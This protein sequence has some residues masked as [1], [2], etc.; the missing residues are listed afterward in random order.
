[1]MKT[2]DNQYEAIESL[3]IG[4]MGEVFKVVD[5]NDNSIKALKI[6]K[7]DLI[8]EL[9]WFKEEF[10]IL[11]Q[12]R[13]PY[14]VRVYNF[15][16]ENDNNPYYTMDLMPGGDIKIKAENCPLDE[17]YK[18]ALMSLSALDYI[19][20]RNII[21]GDL[22]PSNILF[23]E[24]GNLRLVD[25]GL[26]VHLKSDRS[27]SSGTLE[28]ASP[29]IIKHGKLSS[30]SDLYSLG[31]VLYELLFDKP[32]LKGTTSQI[33]A[34]K[35][36]KPVELPEF[37][38]D[39]GG[40]NL[41]QVI[42]RLLENDPEKR[43]QVA[44]E[45]SAIIENLYHASAPEGKLANDRLP[46]SVMSDTSRDYFERASFCGRNEEFKALKKA[47]S[48][49]SEGENSIYYL[50]GESGVGKSRLAEQ[51]KYDIQME[52][53]YFVQSVC[54]PGDDQP[55]APIRK[56][57]EQLFILFDPDYSIFK[58]L[59]D[60]VKRL[61]PEIFQDI[62]GEQDVNRGKQRLFYN[63]QKYIEQICSDNSLVLLVEDL[64]YADSVTI[65]FINLISQSS[66]SSYRPA[67][68]GFLLILTSQI[69]PD[70]SHWDFTK[71]AR[72]IILKPADSEL[73]DE[74]L[75]NLFG[76]FKPPADFS[77]KLYHETGG[78][79]FFAEELLKSLADG[80]ALIRSEGFWKLETEKLTDFPLPGSVKEAISH[81][82]SYLGLNYRAI[83]EQAT[84]MDTLFKPADLLELSGFSDKDNEL[85]DELIL[86]RVFRRQNGSLQ[87]LHN[88]VK[89]VAYNSL[90]SD[91]K[92]KLHYQAAIYFEKRKANPE[93]LAA[94]FLA[95]GE[96]GK[97]YKYLCQSA[98]NAVGIFGWSQAANYYKQIIELIADWPEAPKSARFDALSGQARAL[99]FID[100]KAAE[101]LFEDIQLE[102]VKTDFSSKNSASALVLQAENYQ[103]LGENEQALKLY[104]KAINFSS[105][106]EDAPDWSNILGEAYMGFGW[107]K[108]KLG[109]LD[110]AVKSYFKALDY[111]I[112][113]PERMCRV[114][115]YI[116]IGYARKG[117]FDGALDYYNRSLTVCRENNYKWPAM[118]LYGNIGNVY[119]AKGE[120]DEALEHYKKSLAIALEIS[121]K[122]I[123]G[124]N[125][126]N[127]GHIYNHLDQR[128]KAL[129]YFQKALQIQK[130]IG[131]RGSEAINYN[132]L[133]ET[134]FNLGQLKRAFDYSI[135][136]IELAK[137]IKEPR[138]ELANLKGL[139]DVYLSI[140][141][142][143][144]AYEN[145][146]TALTLAEKLNDDQQK[147]WVLAIKAE[148]QFER[149]DIDDSQK[150]LSDALAAK[151]EH[152]GL[153]ARL[154]MA[155]ALV[156]LKTNDLLSAEQSISTV[157]Q[158]EMPM[159]F[160]SACHHLKA[161][162]LFKKDKHKS[163][164]HKAETEIL[165]AFG[166]AEKYGPAG[167]KPKCLMTLS[168]I[169]R[170]LGEKYE[171]YINQA[172]NLASGYCAGWPSQT[173]G[174]YLSN[175]KPIDE[176]KV[177]VGQGRDKPLRDK[178]M[179]VHMEKS[180]REKRLEALFEAS[181]TVNSI[182][183]LDPLLNQVM[184]L[185]LS[186]LEAD[187]GFIMLKD[188]GD[189]KNGS[190]E[191]MIARNL[192]KENIVGEDTISRSTIDDVFNSGEPLLL[193]IAPG[194]QT[195]RE[196][197]IDFH[198]T[199]IMCAPLKAKDR[200]TGI[201]YIDTRATNR[202]FDNDD[203]DFLLS[204]CNLAAI[205]IEN[206]RLTG[207]LTDRNVYLQKQ[208]EKSSSFKNII[209]RS[210]P[211]QRV[212]RMAESVAV[213]DATVVI[214]GESG[215]G[216]EILAK[217]IHY[218]SLRKKARFIPIDCGALPESLLESELFGHKKGAFTGA[219][220]D[221]IG[222]FEE[223]DN[224]T[225]F[226][227]EITN[228]SQT[229]QVK[230]LRV[231]Q[232]GE[233]RRVGD[234]KSRRIDVRILA[235]TNKD[236]KTEVEAGNFREDLYYRINVVNILLPP[237]KERK[238]DIPILADY[239]LENICNK[240]KMPKKSITSKAIDYLVNYH[241]PG[242][243]RQL[244]NIIE[245]MVIFSKGEFIDASDLPHEIKS[246][247]DSMPI[248]NKTQ[249]NVPSTK[250]E[251]K[252]AKCQLDRLFLVGLMEQAEG[253]VMKAAQ[254]SGTD[255][256]QLHHMLNKY[257]LN[258]V[259]F[260][261]D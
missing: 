210:S 110:Q 80:R 222:L 29:E 24:L 166:H 237:L 245:R 176:S 170:S 31:L 192:D 38:V 226:L 172:N 135:K 246:M 23:D 249:F 47:Y 145:I 169:K 95:A 73:W 146:E 56:L 243:I 156:N 96:K 137:E 48:R 213:S 2:I 35:L 53:C 44:G 179:K 199:S 233:F 116:G 214:T 59:G 148:I 15:G 90:R 239:F 88:Q 185:M 215:T 248:E 241:W 89:D 208:V 57:I 134:Y 238:E 120:H 36:N 115:S 174:R 10:N 188:N 54:T 256:T 257:N 212:F 61:F 126:L 207:R 130:T 70:E 3:G 236:L 14:L 82:L 85:L 201:V 71:S 144:N 220:S 198:I 183:E 81:R 242:N 106:Y 60:E 165:T 7:P 200:A 196:S 209:G 30:R 159:S 72:H 100:P 16:M 1:M 139:A 121:D 55:L 52:G 45:V 33:L 17:F 125:F 104:D 250:V 206:A 258:S 69:I 178:D 193:N 173:Q 255:R 141:D 18:L 58:T 27:R 46:V 151:P 138:I 219:I 94:Q 228:T 147:T 221:R 119:N 149:G 118:Q 261:K 68:N 65:E 19:H 105:E 150:S 187:R 227:D 99:M 87:F 39:K 122:R 62:H 117:D 25:F 128:V 142:T 197:V 133:A 111:F 229:F 194:E 43:Y 160:K 190:L 235:A 11:T 260:K 114:L 164:L 78:N 203:L 74:F 204:F 259:D 252:A 184:D 161:L 8:S 86:L 152:T 223:A 66:K 127:I 50:S 77:E 153:K 129:D 113:N 240:M 40:D 157:S 79:F 155:K 205:A 163:N 231:I 224:G 247:F 49:L 182:H 37:P 158:L 162:Y 76:D 107:V 202:V 218:S 84:V 112:E 63:L 97:A 216:K 34:Y 4:G 13:H 67:G 93:Y 195:D 171:N 12:L 83:V 132:N 253:N 9:D 28:F 21:H 98:E 131:D 175:F 102:A 211:M 154:L 136:G 109:E 22:K 186:N 181:K 251:L 234:V 143:D 254:I 51:F 191:P 26:A 180:S 225:V 6:L 101:K 217:A 167:E 244:E 64:Q 5:I 103:H 75:H 92:I 41:R 140:G 230:L 168:R 177:L 108:S 189:E 124:I 20:S 232:E 91:K 32:L 42:N 123:E